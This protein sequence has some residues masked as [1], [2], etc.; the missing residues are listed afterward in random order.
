MATTISR[1]YKSG[2]SLPFLT[3]RPGESA[4][5]LHARRVAAADQQ[6]AT[7]IP[8]APATPKGGLT[9]KALAAFQK[10]MA[11]YGPEGGFGKGVEAKLE[12]GRTRT[13]ASGMQSLVSSGLAGTTMAAGLGKKYEEEVAAPTMAG[14]ESE[15][16]RSL[17]SLSAAMGGAEQAGFE[18]AASRSMQEWLARLQSGTSLQLAGMRQPTGGGGGG[19][20]TGRQ[21][22]TRFGVSRPAPAPTGGGSFTGRPMVPTAAPSLFAPTPTGKP[23][24]WSDEEMQEAIRRT[25]SRLM[26]PEAAYQGGWTG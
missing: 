15:R 22:T 2:R 10:A 21:P 11:Y 20:Y 17:S 1:T 4:A 14:V 18:S 5:A 8:A 3:P 25:G 23:Q 26:K 19:G 9:P 6:T 7:A 13:V 24:T 12:R 16:A